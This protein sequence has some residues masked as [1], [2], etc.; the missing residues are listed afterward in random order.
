VRECMPWLPPLF[1]TLMCLSPQVTTSPPYSEW[2]SMWQGPAGPLGC[3]E[4][5]ACLAAAAAAAAC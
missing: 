1:L 3:P 4:A 2:G 5:A